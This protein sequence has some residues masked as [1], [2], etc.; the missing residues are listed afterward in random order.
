[1]LKFKNI[2]LALT[3]M[4]GLTF[5]T[6]NFSVGS[7]CPTGKTGLCIYVN[8]SPKSCGNSIN[9]KADCKNG[10]DEALE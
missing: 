10:G 3:F 4:L 1:M 2:G 9:G 5:S 6:V 8:G 7:A